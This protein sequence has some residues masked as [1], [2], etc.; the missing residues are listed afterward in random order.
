MSFQ[1]SGP[2]P[3]P[4]PTQRHSAS[5]QW[6]S[7]GGNDEKTQPRPPVPGSPPTQQSGAPLHDKSGGYPPADP[8]FTLHEH[9]S[10]QLPVHPS[11][12]PYFRPAYNP[13]LQPP[14]QGQSRPLP[15]QAA[16]GQPYY[17]SPGQPA[18]PGYG[19]YLSP[20]QAAPP[21]YPGMGRDQSGPYNGYRYQY[22]YGY[23]PPPYGYPPYGWQPRPKRDGYQF[24]VSIVSTIG[25]GLALLG[26]LISAFILLVVLVAPR[27]VAETNSVF[28]S[29]VMTYLAFSIGGLVGGGFCL[30][31]SIRALLR[32]PSALVRMPWFWIPLVL[33]LFVLGISYALQANNLEV[34]YPPL[35]VLLIILAAIFP[36]LTLAALGV[37]RLR[38]PT[39]PTTW[40]RFTLALV[41]GATLSILLALLLE[42]GLSLLALRSTG[43]I[44]FNCIDDPNGPGCNQALQFNIVFLIIAVIGP[45]VEETV[46]PLGVA[47][48][49]GRLRSAAEAFTLGMA[50]GIGFALVET[51]GYIGSGYSDWLSVALE[52]TGASLL[53]GFGA[54]M[55]ALGWY[56]LAHRKQGGSV[57]IAVLCW[58]YAVFQHL[59]WNG[60]ATLAFLPAP[61][62]PALDNWSINLGFTLLPGLEL[63]NIIEAIL[64]LVFFLYMTGR[65][66]KRTPTSSPDSVRKPEPSSDPRFVARV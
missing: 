19:N 27:P 66:R 60:T 23:P 42:L 59:V 61:T 12:A 30:Y 44:F 1:Q 13:Y 3:D 8:Q 5:E 52:R 29:G 57:L 24:A 17:P 31:H 65:L 28:L 49:S 64:I 10:G 25:A 48:Y 34:A 38:F 37:R 36:A 18:P 2:T 33:Y 16:P 40:R 47:L 22:P 9:V 63:L 50:A 6:G 43:N 41:S 45:L 26:G 51:V 56:H 39:W 7:W 53:H 4:D 14:P 35:T 62:G 20:G 32:K 46:K 21:A 11:E 55:V 58:L 54:G 15:P